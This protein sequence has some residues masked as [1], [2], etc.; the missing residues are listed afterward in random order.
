MGHSTEQ[1]SGFKQEGRD[2]QAGVEG[3]EDLELEGCLS[4]LFVLYAH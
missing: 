2:V 3:P 1:A 4:F